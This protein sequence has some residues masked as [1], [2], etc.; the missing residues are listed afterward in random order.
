MYHIQFWVLGYSTASWP[1]IVLEKIE[2]MVVT[3]KRK[4]L[5]HYSNKSNDLSSYRPNKKIVKTLWG[6][7]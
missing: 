2:I 3:E 7:L 1:Y 4:D 5:I 6:K